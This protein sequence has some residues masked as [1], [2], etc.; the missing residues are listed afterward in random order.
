MTR[1]DYVATLKFAAI[2]IGKRAVMRLLVSR[3]PFFA[4]GF[5][6]WVAGIIV[7]KIVTVLIQDSEFAAFFQ[8]IDMRVD[9]QGDEFSKA[10]QAWYFAS[11]EEK[12]KYEK[13]YL[14]AFYNLASLKS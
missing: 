5:F 7:S 10:A 2:E 9:K 4:G 14:D 1:D 13:A 6:G 12:A 11:P 3:V 8:Y